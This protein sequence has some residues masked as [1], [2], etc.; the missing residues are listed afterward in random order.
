MQGGHRSHLRLIARIC[1]PKP[2]IMRVHTCVSCASD[3]C[4]GADAVCH[5][6]SGFRTCMLFDSSGRPCMDWHDKCEQAVPVPLLW[7]LVSRPAAL[8]PCRPW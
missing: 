3:H 6:D 5:A 8:G 2:G 7:P 4:S 1:S